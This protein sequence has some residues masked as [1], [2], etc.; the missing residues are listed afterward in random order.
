MLA[1]SVYFLSSSCCSSFIKLVITMRHFRKQP[2]FQCCVT[3]QSIYPCGLNTKL[4]LTILAVSRNHMCCLFNRLFLCE[5]V[6]CVSLCALRLLKKSPHI[7]IFC[8]C[9]HK[10]TPVAI[11]CLCMCVFFVCWCARVLLS[12]LALFLMVFFP[13]STIAST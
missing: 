7:S 10:K 4:I 6:F 2:F 5:L 1:I 12:A 11:V 13:S 9:S 3:S 8:C